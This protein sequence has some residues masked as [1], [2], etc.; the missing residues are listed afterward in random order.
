MTGN[1]VVDALLC[2]RDALA[3][4]AALRQ[5]AAAEFAFLDASKRLVLVT[6]HRRESFG[7]GFEQI[8][9]GLRAD[10]ASA[11]TCRSSIRCT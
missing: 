4:D 1:T 10:R 9:E 6:G 5:K 7:H 8:C 2:V 11:T 3:H